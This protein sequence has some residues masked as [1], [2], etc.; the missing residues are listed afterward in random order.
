MSTKINH[1]SKR[2]KEALGKTL[3]V[4]QSNIAGRGLFTRIPIE[5]G[6]R[7]F[8]MF[9]LIKGES[10][11]WRRAQGFALR[12]PEDVAW[13]D[14]TWKINHQKSCNCI[15]ERDGDTWYCTTQSHIPA[16]TELTINYED[17]P[18]FAD[19]N[20]SGFIELE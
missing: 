8:P 3:D 10:Y 14:L 15:I 1:L 5:P 20:V 7:L 18:E 11:N 9:F 6:E 2:I 17:M 13:G 4:R 12:W 16:D 19:R